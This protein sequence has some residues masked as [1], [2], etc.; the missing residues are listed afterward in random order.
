MADTLRMEREANMAQGGGGLVGNIF[1]Q[2]N[3]KVLGDEEI[4]TLLDGITK[5]KGILTTAL[6][7]LPF[8]VALAIVAPVILTVLT[9]CSF[10]SLMLCQAW[11]SISF[12]DVSDPQLNAGV[13]TYITEKMFRGFILSFNVLPIGTIVFLTKTMIP[14]IPFPGLADIPLVF[15]IIILV[16]NICWMLQVWADVYK[17]SVGYDGA[18]SLLGDGFPRMMKS[19]SAI[20]TNLPKLEEFLEAIKRMEEKKE[21]HVGNLK[22]QVR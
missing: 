10:V 8:Q 21:E 1:A 22:T 14:E 2:F 11:Y 15:R 5:H 12:R 3:W 6:V 4:K 20:I 17:A 18:D 13:A 7:Y 9:V 16:G 19:A